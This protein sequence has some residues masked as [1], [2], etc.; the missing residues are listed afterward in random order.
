[1]VRFKGSYAASLLT[2]MSNIDLMREQYS[3]DKRTSQ[4]YKVLGAV[5]LDLV[6]GRVSAGRSECYFF[7]RHLR[8]RGKQ[9]H[10]KSFIGVLGGDSGTCITLSLIIDT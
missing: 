7:S 4:G 10:K 9:H 3:T 2:A 8:K 5:R 6:K 1:M